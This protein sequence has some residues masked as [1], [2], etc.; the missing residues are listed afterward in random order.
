MNNKEI[1]MLCVAVFLIQNTTHHYKAL[2]QN[3]ES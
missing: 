2:Y 3:S 1:G